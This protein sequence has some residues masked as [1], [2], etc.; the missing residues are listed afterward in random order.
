LH[1]PTAIAPRAAFSIRVPAHHTHAHA[2]A[3]PL[4]AMWLQAQPDRAEPRIY[5]ILR[6]DANH[7]R[8]EANCVKTGQ[9]IAIGLN[10]FCLSATQITLIKVCTGS[11]SFLPSGYARLSFTSSDYLW[12]IEIESVR[13]M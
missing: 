2:I 13:S 1:N 8:G 10:I 12:M 4:I 11:V 3:C 9:N 6:C 7:Q 5:P